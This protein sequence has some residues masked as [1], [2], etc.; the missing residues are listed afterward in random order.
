MLKI[1]NGGIS[2]VGRAMDCGS[3]G[4][5]FESNMPPKITTRPDVCCCHRKAKQSVGSLTV[6]MNS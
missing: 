5:W 6:R 3:I 1:P 2:S 4:Y